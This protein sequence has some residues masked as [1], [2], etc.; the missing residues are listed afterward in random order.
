[1]TDLNEQLEALWQLS[2]EG[3]AE[4]WAKIVEWKTFP[5]VQYWVYLSQTMYPQHA[6][7]L[8]TC[9][10]ERWLEG[11]DVEIFRGNAGR[12]GV[13]YE[14]HPDP[15]SA[16]RAW[17]ADTLPEALAYASDHSPSSSPG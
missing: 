8:V 10:A 12:G 4:W 11:R 3:K 7:D 15:E 13:S 14:Y 17:Q 16:F 1:M 9:E 5:E 6:L 2:D